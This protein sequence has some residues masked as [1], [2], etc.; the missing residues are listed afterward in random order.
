[1]N[2]TACK[3]VTVALHMSGDSNETDED[4]T[5]D[6]RTQAPYCCHEAH[7]YARRMRELH[8]TL[9]LTQKGARMTT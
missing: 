5:A 6:K 8:T 1:M 7:R 3:S 4:V 2:P 9:T